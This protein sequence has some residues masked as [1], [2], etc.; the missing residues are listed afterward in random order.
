MRAD[1]QRELFRRLRQPEAVPTDGPYR[2]DTLRYRDEAWLAS[3][4]QLVF[5]RYPLIVAHEAEL[6]NPGDFVSRD[7]A[8]TP[9]LILR[10]DDGDIRVV[11]N[12]CRHRGARLVEQASGNKSKSI[13]CR[14]HA[15]CW[16]TR[17][18]L[19]NVPREDQF[20]NLDRRER[21]L[22]PIASECRHGFVWVRLEGEHA[23]DVEAYLGDTLDDDLASLFATEHSIY[24]HT[25]VERRANWKLIIDAFAEGYHA[26]SLHRSSVARFF[27]DRIELDDLAPHTRQV[28]ARKTLAEAPDGADLREHATLFYTVFPNM[29][30]VVH[31]DFI[32]QL[33][34][35][36][37]AVDKL[38]FEHRMLVP[39]SDKDWASSF[40]L[41]DRTV[42]LKEDLSIV[43][44][45]Q[46]S[47]H[48]LDHILAGGLE[49]GVYLFHRALDRALQA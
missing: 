35:W 45:V 32:S 47:M 43:E 14:Y 20:P 28:G 46:S 38:S 22:L 24:Q 2:I 42:F 7:I 11:R 8:G 16:N 19:I 15:W 48:Q 41:I 6:P 18:E 44:S 4:R 10:G 5:R 49:R 12:V 1:V 27:T 21:G 34:V 37:D 33:S 30:F 25:K 3:E 17:G 29:V 26:R 40:E 13:V 9:L 39:P 31:P 23:V 36:P